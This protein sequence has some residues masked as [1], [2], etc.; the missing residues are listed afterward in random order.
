MRQKENEIWK[1]IHGF[2][3]MYKISSMGRVKSLKR[4]TKRSDGVIRF[5]SERILKLRKY[6]GEYN[7]VYLYKNGKAKNY[8]VH[9][10]VANAFLPNPSK[11]PCINHKDSNPNNN[12]VENLEWCSYSYNIRYSYIFE[13]HKKAMLGKKYGEHHNAKAVCQFDIKGNFVRV[14]SCAKEAADLLGMKRENIT[15]N[16]KGRGFVTGGYIWC[17]E[18][19]ESS[20]MAKV[21]RHRDF[22]SRKSKCKCILQLDKGLVVGEY[23][24]IAS[25]VRFLGKTS[26]SPICLALSGKRRSAYGYQ[27]EYKQRNTVIDIKNKENGKDNKE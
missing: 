2:E 25:A 16:V 7:A 13:N 8:T 3:G 21:Q 10:L 20:I 9:R 24:S 26:T 6:S 27:W 23:E 17:Y 11:Y 1:D 15:R 18:G 4:Y 12:R 5:F 14:F 22:L 19:D